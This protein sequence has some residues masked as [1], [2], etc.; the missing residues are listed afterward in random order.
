MRQMYVGVVYRG[1]VIPM[2]GE[3]DGLGAQQER[4]DP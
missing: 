4:E 3:M 1:S 2:E